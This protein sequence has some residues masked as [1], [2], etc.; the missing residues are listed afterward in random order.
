MMEE[1]SMVEPAR[2][3]ATARLEGDDMPAS[4]GRLLLGWVL[5]AASVIMLFVGWLGVSAN[6][7]VAVQLSYFFSGGFG[8]LVAGIIGV[9]LLVS[10]DIR[11]DRARIGKLEA[12]VLEMREILLAQ[13]ELL[14]DREASVSEQPSG[15][16]RRRR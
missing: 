16:G 5:I 6:P 11:R 10:D 9:G 7:Q 8:G 4:G 13:A 14:R 3:D 15:E 1:I 12:T 2:A